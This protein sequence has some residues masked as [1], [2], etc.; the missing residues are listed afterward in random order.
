MVHAQPPP[1]PAAGALVVGTRPHAAR[2]PV[3]AAASA[4]SD[5]AGTN[6]WQAVPYKPPRDRTEAELL[7]SASKMARTT[8]AGDMDL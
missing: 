1:S 5:V 2:H 7:E 4:S 8:L 6:A 3:N